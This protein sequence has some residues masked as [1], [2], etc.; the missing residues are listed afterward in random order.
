MR[1]YLIIPSWD[2]VFYDNNL[3]LHNY[4]FAFSFRYT[5]FKIT[6]RRMSLIRHATA[7]AYCLN[8]K[9]LLL[10]HNRY[11]S[12]VCLS[13][14]Y[15]FD[16]VTRLHIK[17]SPHLRTITEKGNENFKCNQYESSIIDTRVHKKNHAYLLRTI[18]RYKQISAD[19]YRRKRFS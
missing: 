11:T 19:I 1:R 9:L 8:T 18:L 15:D 5:N 4:I 7:L 3:L 6:S 12:C 2:L 14:K 10:F 16:H 17:A 13:L